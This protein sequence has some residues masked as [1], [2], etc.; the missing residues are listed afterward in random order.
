[1]GKYL[2]SYDKDCM[3]LA[4]IKQDELFRQQVC[5]LHRLYRVQ[6]L[7]MNEM[8]AEFNSHASSKITTPN[9]WTSKNERNSHLISNLR[10]STEGYTNKGEGK[11]DQMKEVEEEES[12]L[13]L[14]LAIGSKIQKKKENSFI[15]DSVSSSSTD[16]CNEHRLFRVP[17]VN[18]DGYQSEKSKFKYSV[19]EQMSDKRPRWIFECLSLNM[20]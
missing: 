6:K 5:E 16:K 7:L 19:E 8:K 20:T 3:K 9:K 12:N 13:E 15:S 14:T 1:M 2:N 11:K 18:L 10:L 4:M 17:N